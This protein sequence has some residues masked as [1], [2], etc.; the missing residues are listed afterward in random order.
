MFVH[1]EV[2]ADFSFFTPWREKRPAWEL[3][4]GVADAGGRRDRFSGLSSP[5]S[6]RP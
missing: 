5:P 2:A 6:L 4:V 1:K 3:G